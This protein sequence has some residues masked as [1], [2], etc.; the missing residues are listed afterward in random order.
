MVSTTTRDYAPCLGVAVGTRGDFQRPS[1]WMVCTQSAYDTIL[2]SEARRTFEEDEQ[3]LPHHSPHFRIWMDPDVPE[4]RTV[5]E[6]VSHP[7][8]SLMHTY[9]TLN[10]GLQRAH[11][12]L[13]KAEALNI[14]KRRR[15]PVVRRRPKSR[16]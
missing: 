15:L 7:F 9:L 3:R 14:D 16:V 12:G 10:Q 11:H 5:S 1:V 4:D 2:R 13:F 6:Q 8:R